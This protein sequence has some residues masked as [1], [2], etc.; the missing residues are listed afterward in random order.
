MAYAAVLID[1]CTNMQTN[2]CVDMKIHNFEDPQNQR[3]IDTHIYT[4]THIYNDMQMHS[5]VQKN[6]NTYRC[7]DL[8]VLCMIKLYGAE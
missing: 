3:N 8:Q 7:A 4:A 6:A 2:R 1:A 5:N